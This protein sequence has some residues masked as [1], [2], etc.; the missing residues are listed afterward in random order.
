MNDHSEYIYW[1]VDLLKDHLQECMFEKVPCGN[2]CGM[3]LQRWA[4]VW[5]LRQNCVRRRLN[6]NHCAVELE[7]RQMKVIQFNSELLC[8]SCSSTVGSLD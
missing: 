1:Y 4:L 2:D 5:H 3:N 8:I 6:C 7:Q